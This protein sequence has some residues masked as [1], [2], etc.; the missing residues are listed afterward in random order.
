MESV[1]CV[2]LG[3]MWGLVDKRIAFGLDQP[4]GLRWSGWG[5]SAIV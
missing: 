5:T 1:K 2:W 3:V 4:C